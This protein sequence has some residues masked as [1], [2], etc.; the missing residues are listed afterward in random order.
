MSRRNDDEWSDINDQSQYEITNFVG[1]PNQPPI[2]IEQMQNKITNMT[3]TN[4]PATSKDFHGNPY[5]KEVVSLD[6]IL[7]KLHDNLD[8]VNGE[9]AYNYALQDAKLQIQQLVL[10][11]IGDD[12]Y[13]ELV[14]IDMPIDING[15]LAERLYEQRERAERLLK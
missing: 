11:I 14:R 15:K 7:D 5:H 13:E 3:I 1:R 12:V 10:T 4:S 6:E 8:Y 2:P 9:N